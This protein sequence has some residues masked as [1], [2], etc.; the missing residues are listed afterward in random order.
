MRLKFFQG[1]VTVLKM[2]ANYQEG[3]IKLTNSKLNKLKYAA[4]SNTGKNINN[5]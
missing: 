2:I 5:N 1:N 4:T 3:K